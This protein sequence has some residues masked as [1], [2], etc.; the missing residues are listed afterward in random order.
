MQYT[1]VGSSDC[2]TPAFDLEG[3]ITILSLYTRYSTSLES[4]HN[5][6]FHFVD[7]ETMRYIACNDATLIAIVEN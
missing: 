3:F 7:S 4:D 1:N 2:F 6:R 5:F